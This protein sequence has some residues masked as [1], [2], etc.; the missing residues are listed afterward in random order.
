[1]S[2]L[3][4]GISGERAAVVM[5]QRE[6]ASPSSGKS[7]N[8]RRTTSVAGDEE[9]ANRQLNLL[10]YGKDA[11]R[12]RADAMML[13]MDECLDM[14]PIEKG[15]FFFMSSKYVAIDEEWGN[16]DDGRSTF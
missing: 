3:S 6:G 10:V 1:M 16:W 12:G 14:A 4:T 9:W 13:K 11:L 8:G 2:H 5:A 7:R 15:S